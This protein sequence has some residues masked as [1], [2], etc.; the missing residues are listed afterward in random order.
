[1]FDALG[2]Q[3]NVTRLNTL[4]AGEMNNNK[5]DECAILGSGKGVFSKTSYITIGTKESC[6]AA[7]I[8][9]EI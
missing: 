7:V 4:A 5:T 1:M 8:K 9:G 3:L 2:A 6:C